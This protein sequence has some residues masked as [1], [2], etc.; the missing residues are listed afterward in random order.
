MKIK[1]SNLILKN[2]LS[3][4]VAIAAF[5]GLYESSQYNYLLFHSI[6][7]IFSIVIASAIFVFAWNSRRMMEND[8]FTIIGIAY[9]FVGGIDFLHAMAYKGMPIF[10][11]GGS[12]LATK[13]W[14][15]ARYVESI[16]I[17]FALIMIRRRANIGLVFSVYIAAV[18]LLLLSIFYWHIF[19]SCFIEGQGLTTFKIG[20]EYIISTIPVSYTHL[21]AHET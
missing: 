3:I 16:S 18:S 2:K 6:A 10:T 20:S 14:I 15:G 21:R 13:L 12:D 4:L 11:G 8:Y 7:E 19:P 5:F 17:L 1:L 9:L